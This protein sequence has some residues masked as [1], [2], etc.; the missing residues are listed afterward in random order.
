[1]AT[2]LRSLFWVLGALGAVWAGG[3]LA[4]QEWAKNAWIW[5]KAPRLNHVFVASVLAAFSAAALGVAW[6]GGL[7]IVR[8]G[9]LQLVVMCGGAAATLFA[10]DGYS[11][12]ARVR[13]YAVALALIAAAAVGLYALARRIPLEHGGPMPG[14]V[15]WSFGVFVLTLTGSGLALVLGAAHVFPW[16]LKPTPSALYGWVFLGSVLFYGHAFLHP[17]WKNAVPQLL[18]FAVYDLVLLVPFLGLLPDVL[19]EHQMS[20]TFYLIVIGYSLALSLYYLFVHPP[21]RLF[22]RRTTPAR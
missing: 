4:D 15:R 7:A 9:A 18:A 11:T 6:L 13:T 19:P 10:S 3:L 2:F 16:P 8:A 21:T 12:D 22:G 17:S 20:L 1:M 14:P 5:P